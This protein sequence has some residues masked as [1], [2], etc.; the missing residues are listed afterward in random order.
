MSGARVGWT[1]TDS[2]YIETKSG[3]FKIN[4]ITIANP[5]GIKYVEHTLSISWE[6]MGVLHVKNLRV[7]KEV[8][9]V[10]DV[11]GLQ[12]LKDILNIL[13]GQRDKTGSTD[14]IVEY[15]YIN[16]KI[17]VKMHWNTP[18]KAECIDS[19]LDLY[20]CEFTFNEPKGTALPDNQ[21]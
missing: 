21:S 5:T 8:T 14:F 16:E 15:P 4:N 6:T 11:V 18:W 7:R 10:Y 13:R 20:K 9:F 17:K 2:G 19:T 3:S 1:V 12:T